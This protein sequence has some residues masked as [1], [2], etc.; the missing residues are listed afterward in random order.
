MAKGQDYLQTIEPRL[1]YLKVPYADQNGMPVFDTQPLTFSWN[2]LFRDNRY[3]GADRQADANQLTLAVST[4]MI[5]QADGFE[6]FSASIGQIRYFQD[7]R[8]RL[9]FEPITVGL[10]RKASLASAGVT[11]WRTISW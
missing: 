8:V 10:R 6:R 7:S 1:F 9:P 3:T 4:R 11:P 2:Q 5:R